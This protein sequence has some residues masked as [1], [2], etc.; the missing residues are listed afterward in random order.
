MRIP[1]SFKLMGHTITVNLIPPIRW[2]HKGAVGMFNT[3]TLTIDVLKRP[4]TITEQTF[5][6]ELMHAVLYALNSPLYENEEL[7]DQVGGML[8][9]AITSAKYPKP[10][11]PRR[12]R[13]AKA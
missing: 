5:L 2:K 9:Q 1:S 11:R 13:K 7:V 4:G 6:H 3:E 8:H 10:R 12:P